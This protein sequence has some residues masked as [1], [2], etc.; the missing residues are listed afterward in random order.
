MYNTLFTLDVLGHERSEL[1][2]AKSYGFSFDSFSFANLVTK[3]T[4][5]F[6]LYN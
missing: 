2:Q 6:T 4:E 3:P 1:V 5:Y